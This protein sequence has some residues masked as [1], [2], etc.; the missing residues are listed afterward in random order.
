MDS[1]PRSARL[2]HRPAPT[3]ARRRT[4]RAGHLAGDKDVVVSYPELIRSSVR[5]SNVGYGY[6]AAVLIDP[7]AKLD[8]RGQAQTS[9]LLETLHL[10]REELIWAA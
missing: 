8:V 6:R 5:L 3:R 4:A 1:K 7:V 2:A 10:L 9:L